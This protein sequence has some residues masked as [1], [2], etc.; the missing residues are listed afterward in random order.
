ML[1]CEIVILTG[2][3]LQRKVIMAMLF[4]MLGDELVMECS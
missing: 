4:T 3:L 2:T 1:K